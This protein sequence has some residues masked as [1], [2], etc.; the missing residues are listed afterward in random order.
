MLRHCGTVVFTFTALLLSGNISSASMAEIPAGEFRPLYLAEDSPLVAIE[1]FS[2]DRLPVTNRDY[3]KFVSAHPKWEKGKVPTVFADSRY[4]QHWKKNAASDSW[5]PEEAML[6]FPVVNV[7]WFAANSYC[8]AFSKKLPSIAQWEY[9]ARASEFSPEGFREP[10]Y[11]QRILNWYAH[12]GRPE[13]NP[14]GHSPANY[15]GIYDLHGMVWE[16]TVDFNSALVSGESRADSS[17]DKKL[18]C[19]AG[20]VNAA[21]PSDYAAFMRYAFRSSLSARYAMSNLGFRCAI[22]RGN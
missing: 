9:V 18:Y 8:R 19:A 22:S 2:L 13:N 14:V 10:G 12:H 1:A 16:W 5:E 20:S 7:S 21:D 17:I 15:W 3:L 4:L 6:D 11:Q